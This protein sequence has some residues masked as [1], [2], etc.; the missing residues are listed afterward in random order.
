MEPCGGKIKAVIIMKN[1]TGEM[2]LFFVV[3][4]FRLV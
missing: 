1:I 3:E 2:S 4:A